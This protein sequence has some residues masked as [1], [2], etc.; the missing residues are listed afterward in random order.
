MKMISWNVNG[1]RAVIKKGFYESIAALDADAQESG[2]AEV[3][4]AAAPAE[5][6]SALKTE[7][8][9]ME[10]ARDAI[11]GLLGKKEEDR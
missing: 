4:A 10:E 7:A 9:K 1:L 6:A 11:G 5:E 8:Q 3:G 2:S